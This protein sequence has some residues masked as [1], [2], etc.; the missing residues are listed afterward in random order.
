MRTFRDAVGTSV[1]HGIIRNN[2]G[3]TAEHLNKQN[4]FY[5]YML[6]RQRCSSQCSNDDVHRWPHTRSSTPR[7]R[8]IHNLVIWPFPWFYYRIVGTILLRFAATTADVVSTS[9]SAL[10]ALHER[11]PA[12]I[13]AL[14]MALLHT[15]ETVV[16]LHW[17]LELRES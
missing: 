1:A 12:S 4:C 17:P 16:H 9:L 10:R 15:H 6:L 2:F 3:I 5:I 11:R 14:I 13:I 7:L 8:L